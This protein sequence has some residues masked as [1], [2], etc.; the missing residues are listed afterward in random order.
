MRTEIE[1]QRK[2]ETSPVKVTG[3][4]ELSNDDRVREVEKEG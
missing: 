2:I 4:G 1:R 3:T